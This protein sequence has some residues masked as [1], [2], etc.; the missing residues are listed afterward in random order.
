MSNNITGGRFRPPLFTTLPMQSTR[1]AVFFLLKT[2]VTLANLI[3]SSLLSDTIGLAS[4]GEILALGCDPD[5]YC[6]GCGLE[7]CTATFLLR[8]VTFWL[9]KVATG[10]LGPL[11]RHVVSAERVISPLTLFPAADYTIPCDFVVVR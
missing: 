10:A 1:Q 2:G 3:S 6:R 8:Q 5:L 4:G 9:S 7:D 11:F